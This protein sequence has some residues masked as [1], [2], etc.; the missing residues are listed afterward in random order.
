MFRIGLAPRFILFSSLLILTTSLSL[1]AFF[2]RH[3]AQSQ[4]LRTKQH[5]ISLARNL[6]HNAELGVLTRNAG[7]LDELGEGLFQESDVIGV[8]IVD[9]EGNPLLD[10]RKDMARPGRLVALPRVD[11]IPVGGGEVR[12]GP[13][14]EEGS[15]RVDAY[16]VSCPVFTRRGTRRNEEIGFLLEEQESAS[17]RLETIG[18][19]RIML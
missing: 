9:S 14:G 3:Y 12:I 1:S 6:A 19:A 15:G 17:Q 4:D 8:A 5:G 10:E 13:F 16:E 2:L 11:I 7:M 18:Y